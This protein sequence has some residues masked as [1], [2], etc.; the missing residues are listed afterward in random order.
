MHRKVKNVLRGTT[1]VMKND[2]DIVVIGGGHAGL[3]AVYSTSQYKEL[4]ICLITLSSV[5]IA[6]APCN[7]SIG[8]VGKG[9][10]VREIDSLGGIM[11]KLA[12]LSG[13]QFR[14]LNESKGY[15]VQSTRIQ[16]DKTLYSQ[17][18][19]EE[20]EK[21]DNLSI[22]YGKVRKVVKNNNFEITIEN[23]VINAK[24][25]IVTVGTF[26]KGKMHLGSEQISG[27]RIN[28]TSSDG[29]QS[30]FK[31]IKT[32]KA[33]FKTGTPPRLKNTSINYSLLE[34]QPSDSEVDH[35]HMF[36]VEQRRFLNQKS[37]FIAYTNNSTMKIIR[38]N[39]EQS[40]MYNGQINA[41]GARY[42]PSIEDK[43]Y[44]YPDKDIHHVFVEPEGLKLDTMY[45][46]GISSSLPRDV[47]ENFVKT[48]PG[49]ENAEIV[50][51]GYAVEYDVVDTTY[52]SHELEHKS[53]SGLYFAGQV[54]GTS[55]YEEAAGQGLIA[56]H[57][58]SLSLLGKAPLILKRSD[59]YIGVMIEDLITNTRD[60]PYRLFTARAENRLY[61]R[62]DNAPLRM[63]SYRTSLGLK[64]KTD[65]Y[66]AKFKRDFEFYFSFFKTIFVD[67]ETLWTGSLVDV[68]RRTSFADYIKQSKEPIVLLGKV[69]NYIGLNI[70]NKLIRC[71][72]VSI[73][74]EGYIK[75]SE[76]SK[77]RISK[78]N[79]K[80]ISW[81][82]I[83]D[84]RNISFE[85]KQRIMKI[86][87]LTFEQLKL[88][89]GIRPATLATIASDSL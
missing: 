6:S 15:A 60:E 74:Y 18:A 42:C 40:P 50:E 47:Q 61:I 63:W 87:P 75:K 52:L 82:D 80:K 36:H 46:S 33:R 1:L 4:R 57:N 69:V 8:G 38:E 14:T 45:P 34:E 23:N 56:G 86:K 83:C 79:N 31:T 9:Q 49:L 84:S 27:G 72:A 54:N 64:T 78:L 41:V 89:D 19:K 85:C 88:I 28:C 68:P 39:K 10:V 71:L 25:L 16:I 44:R 32:G 67:K 51:Y 77:K 7:P 48:I 43:A 30:I 76:V 70:D 81:Q 3:E 58:A 17:N 26:L 37:C 21:L 13:I 66:I 53:V 59:S 2:F 65:L 24:K 5:P 29:L 73:V 12:D 55:G 62:E 11:G 35:F 20:L 22:I